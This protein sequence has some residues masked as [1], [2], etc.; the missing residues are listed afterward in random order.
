MMTA[1]ARGQRPP[2]AP[3]SPARQT[4]VWTPHDRDQRS[5]RF[6]GAGG[7]RSARLRSAGARLEAAGHGLAEVRVE[8]RLLAGDGVEPDVGDDAR[9]GEQWL[10][11][12][13]PDLVAQRERRRAEAIDHD[14]DVSV[15]ERLEACGPV[16]LGVP[17]ESE[18][19]RL[20]EPIRPVA[21]AVEERHLRVLAPG[22]VVRVEDDAREVDLGEL[23]GDGIAERH[24]RHALLPPSRAYTRAAKASV[25]QS[26]ALRTA[27]ARAPRCT[28]RGGSSGRRPTP[29]GT[30]S[31]SRSPPP[32]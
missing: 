6:G 18:T 11:A 9:G 29:R 28:P 22:Q 24:G 19:A 26:A 1:P 2:G 12:A 32:P 14:A 25:A 21:K 20:G 13:A 30:P 15:V 10:L 4:F 17:H 8:G 5:G 27:W 23:D 31:C 7:Q 3:M 16:D